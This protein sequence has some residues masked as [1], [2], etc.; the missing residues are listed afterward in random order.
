MPTR[1]AEALRQLA[2]CNACRYCEGYCAV[3]PALERRRELDDADALQL[4]HLCHDCRACYAACMYTAPHEFALNPPRVLAE[5]RRRSGDTT[6]A[7]PGIRVLRA[8]RVRPSVA[9]GLVA[10]VVLA[11]M[12]VLTGLVRGAT[13]LLPARGVAASPYAVV[14][15]SVIL[16][17]GLGCGLVCLAL[18]AVTGMRYWRATSSTDEESLAT[19]RAVARAARQAATLDYLGGG[20]EGCPYPSTRPSSLRRVFHSALAYG[21]LAC[22]VAT[23]WAAVLQDGLGDQ[24]PY[25]LASGPVLFGVV[26]GLGLLAGGAGLVALKVRS[27]PEVTDLETALRDYLLLALLVLLGASGLVTLALRSTPGFGPAL[28][29]HLD[30][31][32]TGMLLAPYSKLSHAVVRFLALVRD[33]AEERSAS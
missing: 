30:L 22:L 24:P 5:V 1:E 29:L 12:V 32:G 15:H 11:V 18:M 26:G 9:V 13:A 10:I 25:D 17:I 7:P 28:L 6:V 3:F 20:G 23:V 27:T 2:V 8:I 31:V 33:N 14:P 21:F 4:A 16:G 19:L